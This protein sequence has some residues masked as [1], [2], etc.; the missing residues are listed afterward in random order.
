MFIK[1]IAD[2]SERKFESLTYFFSVTDFF[3]P[4]KIEKSKHI[5]E[6]N[7]SECYTPKTICIN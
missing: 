4:Y 2:V 3:C 7:I 1:K 6:I 5:S